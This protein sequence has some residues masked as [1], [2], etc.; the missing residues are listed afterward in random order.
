[1]NIAQ[2]KT[3]CLWV[4][5]SCQSE[6]KGSSQ[7]YAVDYVVFYLWKNKNI[8]INITTK[9]NLKKE[10]LGAPLKKFIKTAFNSNTN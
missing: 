9:K 8:S 10:W 2:T 6:A 3:K 4:G 7:N 1:M 5:Q